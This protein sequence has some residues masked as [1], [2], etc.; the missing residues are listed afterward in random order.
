MVVKLNNIAC[1][2]IQAHIQAVTYKHVVTKNVIHR[3]F[4]LFSFVFQYTN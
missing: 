4:V 3:I 1:S 2:H